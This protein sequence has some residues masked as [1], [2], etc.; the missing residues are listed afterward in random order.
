VRKRSDIDDFITA[1]Y[2]KARARGKSVTLA[3]LELR[4]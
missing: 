3:A 4:K 1:E 2:K